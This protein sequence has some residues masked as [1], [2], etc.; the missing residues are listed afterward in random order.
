MTRVANRTSSS[1]AATDAAESQPAPRHPPF[2]P[3]PSPPR[4]PGGAPAAATLTSVAVRGARSNSPGRSPNTQGAPLA[5]AVFVPATANGG[6]KSLRGG[7]FNCAGYGGSE[8]PFGST[9]PAAALCPP[10]QPSSLSPRTDAGRSA[11]VA[12]PTMA[13]GGD[14]ANAAQVRSEVATP[15]TMV[16]SAPPIVAAAAPLMALVGISAR[17]LAAAAT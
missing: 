11:A 9:P 13:G 17:S 15:P 6:A 7:I 16:T 4:G 14:D 3:P 1:A 8:Q 2:P 12:I 5:V 10:P